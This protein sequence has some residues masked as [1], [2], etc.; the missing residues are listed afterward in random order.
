MVVVEL[1]DELLV[2]A[3][4]VSSR[5]AMMTWSSSEFGSLLCMTLTAE[6]ACNA[7]VSRSHSS[8]NAVFLYVRLT[9]REDTDPMKS[10]FVVVEARGDEGSSMS[11]CGTIG[12]SFISILVHGAGPSARLPD[13]ILPVVFKS[14]CFLRLMRRRLVQLESPLRFPFQLAEDHLYVGSRR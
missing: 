8:S 5:C 11:N 13:S 14:I 4:V 9:R 6:G 10:S 12:R 7:S 3:C 1:G 2:D